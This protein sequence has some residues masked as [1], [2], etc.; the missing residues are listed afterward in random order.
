[1]LLDSSQ[2][3]ED[4][5]SGGDCCTTGAVG[6]AEL[7]FGGIL[8]PVK[9][10]H[11]NLVCAKPTLKPKHWLPFVPDK[12]STGCA[13]V[14]GSVLYLETATCNINAKHSMSWPSRGSLSSTVL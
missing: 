1:M 14:E 11:R 3:C 5:P 9:S 7:F 8:L 13:L 6:A 10:H 12:H 2:S 4:I